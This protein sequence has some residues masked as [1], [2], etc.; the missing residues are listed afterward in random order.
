MSRILVSL[1]LGVALTACGGGG[2]STGSISGLQGPEQVTIIESS[3]GSPSTVRLPRGVRGVDGSDF[4]TDPTNMW[5][6]DD[7]MKSLDTVNMILSSL[8]QTHYWEQT[9]AGPYLCLVEDT[10]R[11]GG[12]GERGQSG[13]VY[14]EWLV[15]STRANN[16]A[17]QHV[18]FWIKQD[19]SMGLSVES[20]I[21]GHLVVTEEPSDAQPL[22]NISLTFKNLLATDP[23][24]S[25]NTM[26]QG[27]MRT[28]PRNDSQSEVE[29]YM[30]KGDPDGSVGVGDFAMRERVHVIGD[31]AAETGRA[32]SE[33]KSVFNPG[34]TPSTE[35]GEF[36][37]QFN[38]DYVARRDVAN[39]NTLSVL[40]RN[41]FDTYVFRYGLYD[42]TTEERVEQLSGFPIRDA[43]GAQG[44]AGYHGI[45]FPDTVALTNGQTV[46]RQ[47]FGSSTT[48]PYT[49]VVV[50]GRLEKR[51]RASLTLADIAGEDLEYFDPVAGVE[52]RVRFDG[53]AFQIV[54]Q[55]SNG[56]WQAV[57]P[58]AFGGTLPTG[59][60][61][62]FWSQARGTVEM[63]W[64]ASITGSVPAYVWSTEVITADSP[65]MANGDLTLFGYFHMLDAAITNTQANFIGGDSPYLSDA[66][67]VNSGNQTY[68]FDKE[69]LMLQLGSVD[70]N[71]ANGVTITQGPGMFGLNCGPLFPAPLASFNDMST[72]TTTFDWRIGSNDWNQ[73]RAL[74]DGNDQY[75]S[76]E[77][78]LRFSYVHDE[79]GSPYHGRTFFVE[80]N[81]SDLH[82]VPYEESS[83]DNRWYPLFN[84]P[85]GATLTSGQSTY[86]VKQL[87]GEQIMVEVGSPS[88]VYA[89]QG[90]DLDGTP[91]TAP[92]ST[93]YEDPAIGAMP[94]ID[95]APRYVAGVLQTSGG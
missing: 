66:T 93:P 86:K 81:G 38:A 16:S 87:E 22:G 56:S 62:N 6:R 34:G 3:G 45:W 19:E 70:V 49:V 82:G 57:T 85:T 80:W 48:T 27:Y 8:S 83:A 76:F 92:D 1:A 72:Q 61:L 41:D 50:P 5:V 84:I 39:S 68:V 10:S 25:T 29:F 15:N 77:A 35:Q 71:L 78:P 59:A 11:G 14:E 20:I 88:T 54:A 23:A 58:S 51:S 67:A 44:W 91:I 74:K 33:W 28:V 46:Y 7:S 24:T 43:N 90:F 52:Q 37:L 30:W 60:W 32:Y 63:S 64:P 18:S 47:N 95:D 65:D 40:D 17:P 79:T 36:Q 75:V 21:Y 53:S 13:P 9:N 12:G 73:L 31:P 69:T 42:N 4:Q 2:G 89:A 55:R 26:F 94:T